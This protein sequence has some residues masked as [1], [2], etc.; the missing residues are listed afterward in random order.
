MAL[1]S[2]KPAC[3]LNS[4]DMKC[5][6]E[7]LN[8]VSSN[9]NNL[10]EWCNV[11]RNKLVKNVLNVGNKVNKTNIKFARENKINDGTYN[12]DDLFPPTMCES[13]CDTGCNTDCRRAN[14]WSRPTGPRE[15]V[16]SNNVEDVIN[17]ALADTIEPMNPMNNL[18]NNEPMTNAMNNAP[19]NN[20]MGNND[21][22]NAMNN[23]A[24]N[25]AATNNAAMNNAAANNAAM[26]NAAMNNAAANNA[27]MNN[28][29]MNNAAANNAAMNNAANNA[30]PV[31]N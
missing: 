29:A 22:M 26:N 21:P 8:M 17:N 13:L 1:N 11:D 20:M 7:K 6:V 27:A 4:P 15:E 12:L 31:N 10:K 23:A 9:Y 28:A 19:M 24:A 3:D 30:A 18:G 25:N 2:V 5:R 16:A 14:C